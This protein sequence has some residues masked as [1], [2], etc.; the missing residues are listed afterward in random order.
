M[1]TSSGDLDN[2]RWKKKIG[3]FWFFG[4]EAFMLTG[5]SVCP[6]AVAFLQ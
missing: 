1:E 4:L 5:K 6:V 2:G 3:V